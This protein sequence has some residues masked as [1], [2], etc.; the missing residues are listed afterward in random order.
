MKRCTK[1]GIEKEVIQFGLDKSRPDGLRVWCRVC[2]NFANREYYKTPGVKLRMRAYQRSL[3]YKTA[4]RIQAIAAYRANPTIRSQRKGKDLSR[5]Y[6]ITAEEYARM[7]KMQ[8][9]V[10]AICGKPETI[11]HQNGAVC[12]L[13][14]DHDHDT[15]RIRGLLCKKCNQGLGYFMESCLVLENAIHYLRK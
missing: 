14:V 9:G 4:K 6:G 11:R 15:G 7:E 1:C 5:K 8:N 12:Q 13:S 3:R 2:T 10:C